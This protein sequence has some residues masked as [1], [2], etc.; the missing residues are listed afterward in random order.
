VTW[1]LESE[2]D[3]RFRTQPIVTDGNR[4]VRVL[5]ERAYR[6]RGW[7]LESTYSCFRAIGPFEGEIVSKEMFDFVNA[8]SE[9]WS[10]FMDIGTAANNGRNPRVPTWY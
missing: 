6:V 1:N 4:Q 10:Y 7:S 9:L 2:G 3:I 5:Y 8:M